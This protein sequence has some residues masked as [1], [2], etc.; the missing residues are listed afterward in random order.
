MDKEILRIVI[1][2]VGALV[3]VGMILW[4]VFKNKRRRGGINF[5][6]RGNPLDNVDESLMMHTEN[7]D[8]DVVPLGSALDEQEYG[9]DPITAMS[10]SEQEQASERERDQQ[11]GAEIP[12]LIQ[13]SLVATADEGFNGADLVQAFER[14]GLEYA[15]IKVYERV[16]DNRMVDF[17]VAS[18]VEP[19]T[20][21]D[22]NVEEF[23]CPGIVFFMQPREVDDPS[24]VFEDFVQTIDMLATELDGVKW[25]HQRQPL[26]D[27]T[28]QEFRRI[29]A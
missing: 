29:L 21:P 10:E 26:S 1:I 14:V 15:S 19:G 7:D 2:A 3:I 8:F 13:F 24:A 20:F 4:S 12:Q 18:M 28:I 11:H 5:Y 23:Y 16:D 17:T 22:T 25:D 6:D 27:E 9:V